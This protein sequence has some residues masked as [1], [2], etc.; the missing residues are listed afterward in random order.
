MTRK[1]NSTALYSV[2]TWDTDS[3]AYTLQ[4]G[5]SSPSQNV[6]IWGLKRVLQELRRG[7]YSCHR[8]RDAKGEHDNNDSYVLVERTDGKI[9]DGRR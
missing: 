4:A 6:T 1:K 9:M 5:L 7:G 2:G 8:F 3:Q